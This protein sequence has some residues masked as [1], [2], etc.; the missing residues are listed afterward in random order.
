MVKKRPGCRF[1]RTPLSFVQAY[2]RALS[3]VT[4]SA[5]GLH[6]LRNVYELFC[7]IHAFCISNRVKRLVKLEFNQEG[8]FSSFGR[9]SVPLSLSKGRSRHLEVCREGVASDSLSRD[10]AC[11]LRVEFP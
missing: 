3:D 7:P 4:H 9:F 11:L 2:P 1:S 5:F 10:H 8:L 6:G